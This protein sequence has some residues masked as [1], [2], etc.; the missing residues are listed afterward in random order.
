MEKA[1][2]PH[3]STLA[4]RIPGTGSLVGCRLWGHTESYTTEATQQQQ[5]QLGHCHLLT[6]TNVTSQRASI[7][8][9]SEFW[10]LH[11]IRL[12]FFSPV[13]CWNGHCSPNYFGLKF[14]SHCWLFFPLVLWHLENPQISLNLPTVIQ[15]ILTP[16]FC[17]ISASTLV[18]FLIT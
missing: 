5:Q 8:L 15:L 1:M 12:T 6:I 16:F 9:K 13:Y 14:W 10:N 7:C 4:W 2:A 17:I 11:N 18:K 3:S